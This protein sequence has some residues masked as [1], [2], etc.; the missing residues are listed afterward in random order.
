M[1]ELKNKTD[2]LFENYIKEI[3]DTV[4]KLEQSLLITT[5]DY[6]LSDPLYNSEEDQISYGD[7]IITTPRNVFFP[8]TSKS[9]RQDKEVIDIKKF[10]LEMYKTHLIDI[11]NE[12]LN[13][14]Y[15]KKS[16]RIKVQSNLYE[17]N[18][19]DIISSDFPYLE[20]KNEKFKNMKVNDIIR[21]V[22]HLENKILKSV[23]HEYDAF[24]YPYSVLDKVY[25]VKDNFKDKN[26]PIDRL[27]F[28]TQMFSDKFG[29]DVD[30]TYAGSYHV[31]I[32]LPHD[33]KRYKLDSEYRKHISGLHAL[34]AHRLQWLE[35]LF[36]SVMSGDPRALGSGLNYPRSSGRSALNE[37]S[38]FGTTDTSFMIHREISELPKKYKWDILTNTLIPNGEY[39]YNKEDAKTSRNIAFID[40]DDLQNNNF[41]FFV[42]IYDKWVPARICVDIQKYS[43][44]AFP[45][46]SYAQQNNEK[47]SEIFIGQDK[48]P[49]YAKILEKK[50]G[51]QL[52]WGTDI[53]SDHCQKSFLF[54]IE[55]GWSKVWIQNSPKELRLHFMKKDKKGDITFRE[56][57]PIDTKKNGKTI[58]S[59]IRISYSR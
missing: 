31:W 14:D 37:L 9:A 54:P 7:I 12:L 22:G 45:T 25:S 6:I 5:T 47:G 27:I 56:D 11:I 19:H 51:Y 59:G 49:L 44:E 2:K 23:H 15:L 57:M 39:F 40:K 52:F 41:A 30:V 43:N 29:E 36:I 17:G 4:G 8:M 16:N 53:R 24:I 20:I 55:E 10:I 1:N 3:Q 13:T 28:W 26:P 32:T 58:S 34:L 42:N 35:P 46:T 48:K 21:Q 38:G 33:E 18:K 50:H